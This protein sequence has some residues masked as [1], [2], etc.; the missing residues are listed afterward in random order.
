MFC[1][2]SDGTDWLLKLSIQQLIINQSKGQVRTCV[3][4]VC[5]GS[6]AKQ[7]LHVLTHI[8]VVIWMLGSETAHWSCCCLLLTG[9]S[10]RSISQ[11]C[12]SRVYVLPLLCCCASQAFHLAH[13]QFTIISVGDFTLLEWS[14]KSTERQ[15]EC[16]KCMTRPCKITHWTFLYKIQPQHYNHWQ[17]EWM[18]SIMAT[19]Q[20]SNGKLWILVGPGI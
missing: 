13:M 8:T 14:D 15:V 19:V 12:V 5:M 16:L 20:R 11:L 6:E 2:V 1:Y 9:C 4:T 10:L 3:I 7:I 18:S 17:I